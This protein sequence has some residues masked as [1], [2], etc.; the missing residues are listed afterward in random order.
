[1]TH[2]TIPGGERP[3]PSIVE[4]PVG[5][6]GLRTGYL[7]DRRETIRAGD[8]RYALFSRAHAEQDDWDDAQHCDFW[9]VHLQ[10]WKGLPGNR[11]N[12]DAQAYVLVLARQHGFTYER[13]IE[14]LPG[15][16]RED[17]R[18]RGVFAMAERMW[19]SIE[20]DGLERPG[21]PT[22]SHGC[23]GW[24]IPG[25]AHPGVIHSQRMWRLPRIYVVDDDT[26]DE[27]TRLPPPMA[28]HQNLP[29]NFGDR[30]AFGTIGKA[31]LAAVEE[32]CAALNA[33]LAERASRGS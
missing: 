8:R 26:G 7:D 21:M 22:V 28:G 13:M 5:L 31:S 25:P 4:E 6:L 11:A 20:G 23:G 16:S 2:D 18:D 15:R 1:M 3:V 32:G 9:T 27:E 17:L 30:H 10:L 29:Q 14:A 19:A 33:L 24:S 12:R